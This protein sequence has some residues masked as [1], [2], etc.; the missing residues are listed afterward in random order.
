MNQIHQS[1][2]SSTEQN[3]GG[4]ARFSNAPVVH[5]VDRIRFLIMNQ[6][7]GTSEGFYEKCLT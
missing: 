5:L 2:I 3:W 7:K 6:G 1:N 4:P